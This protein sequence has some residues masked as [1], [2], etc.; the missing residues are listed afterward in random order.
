MVHKKLLNLKTLLYDA[1]WPPFAP[2][3]KYDAQHGKDICRKLGADSVRFGCI[4]KYALY[5]SRIYPQH[6]DLAGRD[7]LQ[8]TIETGIKVIAYIPVGHGVPVC[9]LEKLHPEWMLRD[10][11][12]NPIYPYMRKHN[13]GESMGTICTFGP[14]YK[15]ILGVVKEILQYPIHGV[16]LDGPYHAWSAEDRICQCESCRR[17][18]FAET[19]RLLPG[20]DE[21]EQRGA[22]YLHWKRTRL[23]NLLREI[24]ALAAERDLPLLFNRTAAQ[25]CGSSF[26]LEM[27]QCADGFLIESG[28]G[29]LEGATLAQ[30][31]DKMIWDYTNAHTPYPRRTAPSV[32][33]KGMLSGFRT[34]ALGGSPIVSFAGRF[35]H[36]DRYTDPIRSM[37]KWTDRTAGMKLTRFAAVLKPHQEQAFCPHVW[38]SHSAVLNLADSLARSGVPVAILPEALLTKPEIAGTYRILIVNREIRLAPETENALK[39]FAESGGTLVFTGRVPPSWSGV[40]AALPDPDLAE[41]LRTQFSKDQRYD[42]YLE[43]PATGDLLPWGDGPL[44]KENGA[45]CIA[46]ARIHNRNGKISYPGVFEHSVGAGRVVVFAA[47]T[48]TLLSGEFGEMDR[49][50]L[51][52]LLGSLVPPCRLAE[53][54]GRIALT[55]LTGGEHIL[56]VL[57]ADGPASCTILTPKMK[58]NV[59]FTDFTVIEAED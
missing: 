55:R 54:D 30:L 10:R 6:P 35:F 2:E 18:Y 21:K 43:D 4:G 47:E 56:Y 36:S 44:L 13:G 38:E 49:F 20:E 7:L 39:R 14:Y 33:R 8:E 51:S 11:F 46:L 3:L 52:A 32:E 40:S 34:I 23:L 15:A 37:L 45:H 25:F 53:P 9:W 48:E 26:E 1:Y 28:H 59:E 57:C 58:K 17:L 19:D 5:P 29:G 50:F 22:E 42:C 16:Y 12:N 24:K 31:Y 41:A 27:L